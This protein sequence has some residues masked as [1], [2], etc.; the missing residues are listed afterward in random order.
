MDDFGT[1]LWGMLLDSGVQALTSHIRF[2]ADGMVEG[3]VD[4]ILLGD[5]DDSSMKYFGLIA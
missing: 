5:I 2:L 4:G 3:I 1:E